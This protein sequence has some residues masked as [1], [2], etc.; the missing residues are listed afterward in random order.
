MSATRFRFIDALRGAAALAVLLSHLPGLGPVHEWLDYGQLG[1]PVFFVISGFVIAAS[2][3]NQR[4]TAG[5]IGRFILRRS[6]RLDPP[7]W[8][9]LFIMVALAMPV[10][11]LDVLSNMFYLQ[12]ILNSPLILSVSWTL[13]QE[14]QLYLF[15]VMSMA[16]F[17]RLPGNGLITGLIAQGAL[18]AFAVFTGHWYWHELFV[19]YWPQFFAGAL[20]YWCVARR[21]H[22]GFA[23]A[24]LALVA[25]RLYMHPAF[26]TVVCTAALLL[27]L[28]ERMATLGS[29]RVPQFFGRISYSL[30]LTHMPVAGYLY[31]HMHGV[32]VV[33]R[34]V[35]I[36]AA[37]LAAAVAMYFL[38]ERTAL[39]WS[40]RVAKTPRPHRLNAAAA[41]APLPASA[42]Q[43]TTSASPI[44]AAP[45]PE[46]VVAVG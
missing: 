41:A 20:A 28:R 33:P 18:A 27:I 38:V 13:C 29:G 39:G 12:R 22:W 24:F 26:L 31:D 6:L 21:V 36:L 10:G 19:P 45:L 11:P 14:V 34:T 2:N 3:A 5:Y 17:Q 4:L 35:I 46:P 30:Y 8:T 44:G 25:A 16:L 23:V 40:A 37:C 9:M 32:P 42:V 1:V 7:Y 15:Y 43:G